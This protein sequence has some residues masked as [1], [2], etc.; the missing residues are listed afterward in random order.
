M[1]ERW[2]DLAKQLMWEMNPQDNLHGTPYTFNKFDDSKWLTGEGFAAHG[3]GHYSADWYPTAQKYNPGEYTTLDVV[4][5]IN[6]K[7]IQLKDSYRL[8]DNRLISKKDVE[9]YLRKALRRNSKVVDEYL[10]YAMVNEIPEASEV[11]QNLQGYD[12]AKTKH[13]G[14]TYKVNV[15]NEHFM[16]K[17]GTPLELQNDFVRRAVE[18]RNPIDYTK[19]FR[20]EPS[21]T[22]HIISKLDD[23]KNLQRLA[24]VFWERTNY[25]N[26]YLND[27]HLKLASKMINKLPIKKQ[28]EFLDYLSGTPENTSIAQ[29][30]QRLLGKENGV[31]G[32]RAVGYEDGPINVTFSDKNIKMANTPLQRVMNRIPTQTLGKMAKKILESP[33]VR[34]GGKLLEGSATPLMI[35]DMLQLQ[36]IDPR[37]VLDKN[38]RN[39]LIQQNKNRIY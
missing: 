1:E 15:P 24:K 4:D 8:R 6:N 14:N 35:L 13:V 29:D 3:P 26:T 31:K 25:A 28:F 9:A 20:K 21:Y 38:Y 11:L 22:A 36:G 2:S 27:K 19:Y 34:V 5:K 10:T 33:A 7:P 32:V 18:N 39:R 17:E 37:A 12:L 23:N 30:I 16:W